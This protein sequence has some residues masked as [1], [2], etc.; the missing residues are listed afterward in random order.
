MKLYPW[1]L[2][3][4]DVNGATELNV[5]TFREFEGPEFRRQEV[6]V[7]GIEIFEQVRIDGAPARKLCCIACKIIDIFLIAL[8]EKKD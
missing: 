8:I 4:A 5:G 3:Q 7:H 6:A 2:I 1:T